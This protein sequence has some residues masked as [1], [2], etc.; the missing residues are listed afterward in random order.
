VLIGVLGK[1]K[2]LRTT[3]CLRLKITRTLLLIYLKIAYCVHLIMR[4][5]VKEKG[6]IQLTNEIPTHFF[7]KKSLQ[8]VST[9]T[10]IKNEYC[11]FFYTA[12]R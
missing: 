8:A 3:S 9:P 7:L 6:R 4:Y 1:K 12:G 2:T 5:Q 10:I 11:C